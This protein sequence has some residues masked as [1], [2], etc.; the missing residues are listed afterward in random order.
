MSP[1]VPPLSLPRGPVI[2]DVAG[3]SLTEEERLRLCHPLVGGVILFTRNYT[4]PGQLAELCREIASLR[5]PALFIAVDH[6]GGRVQRFRNGFTLLPAMASL[7]A[8]WDRSPGDALA[9]SQ[10]VGFVL[11]AELRVRGVDFSFTPVLDM[12]WGHS[13]VIGNR[14][15]HRDPDGVI[16]LARGLLAGLRECG[17]AGCGK[18]F[19]GHGWAA[20]DSHV[21]LPEDDRSLAEL[22]PDI[23]PFRTLIAEARLGAVMPAHVVYSRQDPRPAGF[24]PFWHDYLRRQLGFDGVVFSDDLS[25]EGASVAGDV[26]ARVEAAWRAGCDALLVCNAPEKV[27][28]VLAD[29]RPDPDPVAD[30][31]RLQRLARLVPPPLPWSAETLPG[32]PRY[33]QALANLQGFAETGKA[34]P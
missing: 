13:Q 29:W 11:A 8:L 18:H 34:Q 2:A 20:A 14:A 27:D 1:S 19:P 7:G 15:F 23:R 9:L 32:L 24:S 3:L 17:M 21:A 28:R 30:P 26:L 25:M 6:E 10:D 16:A 22:E 5:Q 31:L 12:A 4:D 33:R